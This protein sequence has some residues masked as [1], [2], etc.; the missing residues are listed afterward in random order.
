V[1]ATGQWN[2]R[3]VAA[4]KRFQ[5]DQNI[6]NYSGRGKLDSLTLIA[7]GLGPKRDNAPSAPAPGV[8]PEGRNQ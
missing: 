4:L 6:T 1:E 3:S 5:E 8:V 7:L 2:E